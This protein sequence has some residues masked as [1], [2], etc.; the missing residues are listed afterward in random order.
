[1]LDVHGEG[2]ET[3]EHYLFVC[4]NYNGERVD[5]LHKLF[6]VTDFIDSKI[7]LDVQ[8]QRP[9]WKNSDIFGLV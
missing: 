3:V 1:M 2:E 6:L 4:D 9:R 7:H 5:L 8:R